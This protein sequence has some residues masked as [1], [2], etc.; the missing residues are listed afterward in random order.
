MDESIHTFRHHVLA[1]CFL[2]GEYF[3]DSQGENDKFLL[4]IRKM[5]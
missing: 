2:F 3:H 1:W 4:S 5:K